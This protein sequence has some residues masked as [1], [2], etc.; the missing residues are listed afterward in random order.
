MYCQHCGQEVR[1]DAVVCI[2]CGCS[3]NTANQSP[4]EEDKKDKLLAEVS[5]LIPIV[6]LI[7]YCSDKDE[8]PIR[9][10]YCGRFALYGFIFTLVLFL[11]IAFLPFII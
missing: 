8:K 10:K 3:V 7:I 1:E 6:G 5:F 4:K 2:H 11:L 9:A